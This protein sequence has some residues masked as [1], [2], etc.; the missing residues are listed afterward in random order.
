[1]QDHGLTEGWWQLFRREAFARQTFAD[2]AEIDQVS[3]LATQKLNQ[4]AKPWFGG[5]PCRQYRRLR[6]RLVYYL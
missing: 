4:R 3:V 5:R 2:A 1:V 6:R